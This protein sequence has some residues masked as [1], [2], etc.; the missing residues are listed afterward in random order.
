MLK[1]APS[2]LSADFSELKN[3]IRKAEEGGADLFH[4]DIM[5][6]HFVPN[7]TFG[8][9]IVKA[10]RKL[11]NLPLDSHLMI[12]NPDQYID[13]FREAGSDIIT[14]HF[15]ACTHLHRT[16]TKIKQTGAK[17]GVSINPA[18]PVNAIEEI[19]D[20]VDILL[21][22]SV[23]PGFGGQKFIETSLR[24]IVQAKKM[25]M[26][27]NLD[28]EIEVDG[29]IDLDNVELI[30][31]AGAD[32]IV[33]GSSIFKSDDVTKTVKKFK[34]KFLEFEFKNKVKLI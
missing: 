26:E 25:I 6:G 11:T 7:L 34:E 33:A 4:L 30:L 12:S 13:E 31:E 5:D 21:I 28:V 3:E 24:K 27:R 22:M 32:I 14:V 9:M 1:L 16:I 15:E 19:I 2:L 20:Y 10:I 29:G 18:T 23:N 8:P 17:A